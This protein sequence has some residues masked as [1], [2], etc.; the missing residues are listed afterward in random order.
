MKVTHLF[1]AEQLMLLR[2]QLLLRLLRL[3][4]VVNLSSCR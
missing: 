2:L 4:M 3:L 1:E